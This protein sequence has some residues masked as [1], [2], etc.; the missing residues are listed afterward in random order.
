MG[1][2]NRWENCIKEN[3]FYGSIGEGKSQYCPNSCQ[4]HRGQEHKDFLIMK[5]K[6]EGGL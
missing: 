3:Q 2:V 5:I 6:K 1:A 4:N